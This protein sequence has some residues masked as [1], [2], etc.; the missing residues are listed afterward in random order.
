MGGIVGVKFAEMQKLNK[1]NNFLL[2]IIIAF[3][4]L[5]LNRHYCKKGE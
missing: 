5:I 1:K 2:N 4:I 3:F